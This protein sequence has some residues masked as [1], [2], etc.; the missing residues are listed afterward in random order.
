MSRL[1]DIKRRVEEARTESECCY[2]RPILGTIEH[3]RAYLLDLV[4]RAVPYMETFDDFDL[5]AE[6][7]YQI[8][9]W[10]RDVRGDDAP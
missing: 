3:D 10:L 4:E 7:Q 2:P 1:D 9:R 5:E 8:Q 6:D